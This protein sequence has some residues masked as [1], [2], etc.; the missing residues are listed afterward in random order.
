LTTDARRDVSSGPAPRP[1]WAPLALGISFMTVLPA[2]QVAVAAPTMRRAIPLFPLIGAVL[3]AAVGMLGLALDT[4][5]PPAPTAALLLATGLFL[6]GALHLD[7]L[8][9]TA[10]GVFGGYTPAR[11][12]E[13][14]RDS[15]VGAFGALAAAAVLLAQFACL[16]ELTGRERLLALTLGGGLGRWAIV[17]AMSVFPPVRAAGL[18]LGVTFQGA[19][20]TSTFAIGSIGPLVL[21]LATRPAGLAALALTVVVLLGGGRVLAGRLG[22][23]TGDCYGALAVLTETAVLYG[24]LVVAR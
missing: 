23:L 17:A 11:R 15:R 5:L 4:L 3:G 16:S 12:L 1:W 22:G 24:V 7:G 2:P 6:T 18:G 20:S 19:A 10:D 13:I 21:A 8:L 14:M 9:D